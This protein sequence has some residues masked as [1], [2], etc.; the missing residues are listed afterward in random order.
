MFAGNF[1]EFDRVAIYP[2]LHTDRQTF[3]NNN[4]WSSR[5]S[6][7]GFSTSL[8]FDFCYGHLTFSLLSSL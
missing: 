4:L 1:Y 3:S 5:D 8:N 2:A 6:K 7:T